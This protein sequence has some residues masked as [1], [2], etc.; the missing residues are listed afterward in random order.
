VTLRTPGRPDRERRHAVGGERK[1]DGDPHDHDDDHDHGDDP[2]QPTIPG[3]VYTNTQPE[4]WNPV[5]CT[6]GAGATTPTTTAQ[7]AA[8]TK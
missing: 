5:P 6:L 8:K 3:N 1:V 7:T 4:P 2:A